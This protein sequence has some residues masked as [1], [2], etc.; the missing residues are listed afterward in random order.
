[1]D[2]EDLASI[3][4]IE[5]EVEISELE[6]TLH[7]GHLAWTR[8]ATPRLII[9]SHQELEVTIRIDAILHNSD[10][11]QQAFHG[12]KLRFVDSIGVIVA[13]RLLCQ[14]NICM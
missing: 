2:P 13:L 5:P 6:E 7:Q 8:G 12:L 3:H 4:A 10:S 9:H 1:M 11:A 14:R